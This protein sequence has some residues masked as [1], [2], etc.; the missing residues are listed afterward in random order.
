MLR[1]MAVVTRRDHKTNA[2]KRERFGVPPLPDKL[3]ET[4]LRW[5][6]Q[7]T[8]RYARLD[9][10]STYKRIGKANPASKRDKR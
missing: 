3:R 1:W 4:R 2:E 6:E 8:T 7:V 9:S 5:Y 10:V